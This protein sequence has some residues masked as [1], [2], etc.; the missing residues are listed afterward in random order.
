MTNLPD[1]AQ[2]VERLNGLMAQ[3]ERQ[4]QADAIVHAG[5]LREFQELA[6]RLEALEHRGE[7]NRTWTLPR[8]RWPETLPIKPVWVGGLLLGLGFAMV[9]NQGLRH[10]L[11]ARV[12]TPSPAVKAQLTLQ[13]D[14]RSWLEVRDLQ[15]RGV[16]VGE[17]LGSRKFPLAGGLQ[18]LAGRPDLVRVQVGADPVRVLGRV[19]Q[20]KWTTFPAPGAEAS[21]P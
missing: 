9:L 4:V 7:R 19:D 5:L 2:Q 21:N 14:E 11:D 12:A 17:L 10:L 18:V 20:V 8:L 16:Y 1:E 13:A 6:Q 3:L 15:G